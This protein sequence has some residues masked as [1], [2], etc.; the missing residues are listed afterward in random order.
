MRSTLMVCCAKLALAVACCQAAQS[1][2]PSLAQRG[3]DLVT[4][5]DG[6]RLRGSVLGR[7]QT[8]ATTIVVRSEWLRANLPGLFGRVIQPERQRLAGILRNTDPAH[9]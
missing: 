6:T 3:V 9:R 2:A 8:G 1:R 4:L 7:D 5:K